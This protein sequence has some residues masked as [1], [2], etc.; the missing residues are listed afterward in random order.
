MW[1]KPVKDMD[2]YEKTERVCELLAEEEA[3]S[4]EF[5]R[6][7]N[8]RRKLQ[9]KDMTVAVIGQFKRGKSAVANSI[10]G[11]RILPVG[12]VPITSAVTKVAYGE[13]KAEVCFENGRV[14]EVAF[15]DLHI[16]ISE[17][18]NKNN[19]LEIKEIVLHS[20]SEFLSEG[21]TF[22]DTPGVGSFHK[23]NTEV[24]Y[25]HMKESDAVIFLLSVD[26]PIN[27]IEIDFLK[28]ARE[29]A[30]RFY[31]AVN[32]VD[33]VSPEELNTYLEYCEMVLSQLMGE[34][35][36]NIFPV[37]AKTG[38]GME[39]L[40]NA[41]I[42]DLR[43]NPK[44]IMEDSTSKKL[45]DLIN[46]GISQLNFYWKAMNMEYKELD[47]R[48]NQ[49]ELTLGDIKNRAENC[50]GAYN[51]FINEFKRE[52][53][54]KVHELFGMEYHY[55]LDL[56]KIGLTEMSKEE[57]IEK[58]DELCEDLSKTLNRILLYR[59]EN[60]YTVCHRINKI[61]RLT[62]ELRRLRDSLKAGE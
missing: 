38:E 54:G 7:E 36:I 12:I 60:A 28:N 61:N 33:T 47:A 11:D 46:D 16:Y 9:E 52:L 55:D 24:A 53:S 26:S 50:P 6:A 15:E 13:K 39:G 1:R 40:K 17:Q 18:E 34:K 22:V 14:E 57:F 59:E 10:L 29:F 25:D 42:S 27:Q 62:R 56:L 30:A 48:F 5:S 51:L 2:I 31:F 49:I 23:N 3:V 43:V 4:G 35:D 37:S 45:Y 21:L 32:K 8:L 19:E 58:T 44:K 20:P 41:I